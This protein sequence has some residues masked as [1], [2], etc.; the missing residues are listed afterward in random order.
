MLFF[1]AVSCSPTK[2]PL[3]ISKGLLLL[4]LAIA[5]P[6][7]CAP[8]NFFT[9]ELLLSKVYSGVT[10]RRLGSD[11]YNAATSSTARAVAADL[12]DTVAPSTFKAI[13]RKMPRLTRRFGRRVFR[14]FRKGLR[15]YRNRSY[16]RR[17]SKYRTYKYVGPKYK[18]RP[19]M[20]S[21][22]RSRSFGST[23]K[24]GRRRY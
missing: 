16:R 7:F 14:R 18:Y 19:Y 10:G 6:L 15:K 23:T 2:G 12:L 11:L 4:P 1:M 20:K 13:T 24:F 5:V 21:K 9:T 3:N 22:F 17:S 8:T